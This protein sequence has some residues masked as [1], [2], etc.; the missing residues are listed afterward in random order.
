MGVFDVGLCS[1]VLTCVVVVPCVR[2][3]MWLSVVMVFCGCCVLIVVLPCVLCLSRFCSSVPRQS[4]PF[5]S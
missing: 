1:D 2:C 4:E 5:S 3:V